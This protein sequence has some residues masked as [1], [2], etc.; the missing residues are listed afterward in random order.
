MR[1]QTRTITDVHRDHEAVR[2]RRAVK[3]AL[4]DESVAAYLVADVDL[5]FAELS[6]LRAEQTRLREALGMAQ[7]RLRNHLVD[8]PQDSLIHETWDIITAAISSTQ[9]TTHG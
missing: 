1:E 5:L 7:R 4:F 8:R 3:G 6:T 9:E 2:A